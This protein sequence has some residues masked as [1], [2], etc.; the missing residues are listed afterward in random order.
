MSDADTLDLSPE[1]VESLLDGFFK[2]VN[3]S[4]NFST[5]L[6]VVSLCLS[7]DLQRPAGGCDV[8]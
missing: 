1:Q 7:T 5:T 4:N 2:A 3:C 8:C 6:R